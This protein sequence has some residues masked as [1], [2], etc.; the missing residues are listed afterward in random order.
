MLANQL[1]NG[2]SVISIVFVC[3]VVAPVSENDVFHLFY[4]GESRDEARGE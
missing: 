3:I 1:V 4:R 2:H